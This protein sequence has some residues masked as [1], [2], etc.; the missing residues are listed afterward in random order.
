V[1]EN[2]L[3]HSEDI[4]QRSKYK[5]THSTKKPK[6]KVTRHIQKQR[7]SSVRR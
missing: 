5:E 3:T 1:S 2:G 6:A 7:G 4:D